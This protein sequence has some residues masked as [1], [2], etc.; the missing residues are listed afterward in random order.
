MKLDQELPLRRL[1]TGIL[2]IF[3]DAPVLIH[4]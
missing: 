2:I 4:A 1:C 3:I